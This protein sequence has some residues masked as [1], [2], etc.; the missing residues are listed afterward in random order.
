MNQVKDFLNVYYKISA[1]IQTCVVHG[2]FHYDN[3][4]WDENISRL[5]VIDFRK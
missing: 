2:D 4:L 1:S 5:G 3:I